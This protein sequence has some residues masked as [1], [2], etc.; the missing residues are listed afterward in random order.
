MMCWNESPRKGDRFNR[1]YNYCHAAEA[2]G[3]EKVRFQHASIHD[4]HRGSSVRHI[5]SSEMFP[6][7]TMISMFG[8][9]E[10]KRVGYLPPEELENTFFGR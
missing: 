6:H 2:A 9:T 3:F 7:V 4:Q 5:K 10:C 8:L 1:A